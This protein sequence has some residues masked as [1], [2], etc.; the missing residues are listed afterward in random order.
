M[1]MAFPKFKAHGGSGIEVGEH[2]LA[3]NFD[4]SVRLG[5]QRPIG[6]KAHFATAQAAA[7]RGSPGVVV[8]LGMDLPLVG[9]LQPGQ[10]A[11]SRP[12]VEPTLQILRQRAG[13]VGVGRDRQAIQV[14]RQRQALVE[15][16]RRT[17]EREGSGQASILDIH[18]KQGRAQPEVAALEPDLK[19]PLHVGQPPRAVK[20]VGEVNLHRLGVQ[21][22][23]QATLV[24][25]QRAAGIAQHRQASMGRRPQAIKG[26]AVGCPFGTVCRAFGAV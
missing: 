15:V 24:P 26:G 25:D 4:R 8:R 12:I 23:K 17:A 2:A 21:R 16:A 13:N 14:Q 10:L 5:D 19:L 18:P 22:R 11:L 6:L 3:G 7:D 1:H 20:G 9:D